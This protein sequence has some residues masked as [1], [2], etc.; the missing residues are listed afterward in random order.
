MSFTLLSVVFILIFAVIAFK[1]IYR[2]AKNGFRSAMLSL[3]ADV[4]AL[5]I[6]FVVNSL[7]SNAAADFLMKEIGRIDAYKGFAETFPSLDS[8][9][10][11]AMIM[12]LGSV[13]YIFIYL[14]LRVLTRTAVL[15]IARAR[16]EREQ[17]EDRS[18]RAKGA[19]CGFLSAVIL[20]CALS[21]PVMGTLTL[22]DH[23]LHIVKQTD[24][25]IYDAIGS[26]N[27]ALVK[28]FTKDVAAN[29]FY[30]I[31]GK[32]IYSCAASCYVSD[33][34]M[35]LLSE[36]K[37]VSAMSEDMLNV[38]TIFLFPEQAQQ[39]HL[40]SLRRLKEN[41][42]N[43]KLFEALSAE[44]VRGC[45]A[46]WKNG[47]SFLTICPPNVPSSMRSVFNGVLLAC[48]DTDRSNVKQNTATML[49]A[50]ALI[51]GS[52]IY[53]VPSDDHAGI[54]RQI[55]SSGV[56]TDLEALLLENPHTKQVDVSDVAMSAVAPVVLRSDSFK[57]E[58]IAEMT[59]ALKEV[60]AS[61][62]NASSK[63]ASLAVFLR[64]ILEERELSVS[65]DLAQYAARRMIKELPGVNVDTNDM[66]R[67]MEKYDIGVG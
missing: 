30:Q 2:G 10:K 24:T 3:G 47:E 6:S 23:V 20:V 54:L 62:E 60:N 12:L 27:A 9:L 58:L 19:V 51:L 22:A 52:G 14:L 66:T 50:Y 39:E 67:L 37:T 43:L 57:E 21:A 34:K 46:A 25:R 5:F 42:Q 15:R 13:F 35:H 63:A 61:G 18:D 59:D 49:E 28:D 26:G 44:L 8:V 36:V 17:A 32:T 56:L 1:E 38:Y 41:M 31:G 16:T 53:G 48:A 33:E 29:V 64:N 7:V 65:S 45:A 4:L 40:D 55:S 11:A